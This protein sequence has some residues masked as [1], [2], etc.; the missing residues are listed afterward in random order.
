LEHLRP[1]STGQLD[2]VVLLADRLDARTEDVPP[3][4]HLLARDLQMASAELRAL[5]MV[6]LVL[7]AT[8]SDN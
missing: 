3:E 6:V 1:I 7:I 8:K 5:R 4:G 2:E